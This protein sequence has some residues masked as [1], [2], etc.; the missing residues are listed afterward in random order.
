MGVLE[1]TKGHYGWIL[2]LQ[3]IDHPDA[4]KHQG[5]IYLDTRDIRRGTP[6]CK[7]DE[8]MF[9]LYIDSR[10]LGAEDC[11]LK[12][13]V[14]VQPQPVVVRP[15]ARTGNLLKLNLADLL[16]E[17]DMKTEGAAGKNLDSEANA[18]TASTA[19][20]QS[21]RDNRLA[22][23][24]S[25]PILSILLKPRTTPT[26]V[27]LVDS[28]IDSN[29][30][31][32]KVESS[33]LDADA[34]TTVGSRSSQSTPDSVMTEP[35]SPKADAESF[36]ADEEL[37][38]VD[39]LRAELR[40]ARAR[41]GLLAAKFEPKASEE[42]ASEMPP[43][44]APPPGLSAPES[45]KVAPPPGLAAPPAARSQLSMEELFA[46]RPTS[47]QPFRPPPGFDAPPGLAA[48][49]SEA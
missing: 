26:K 28:I 31:G 30:A 38:L 6:L 16:G 35:D 32:K 13:A 3:E 45:S 33:C 23:F 49:E 42:A 25:D 7:G 18:D 29:T 41:A 24:E 37:S 21:H 11:H 40:E 15:K 2:P 20:T 14:L 46:T 9:Y 5:G 17:E 39:A 43:G 10:G 36:E 48:P 19:S 34:A 12:S 4:G 8:V 22:D 44:F 27:S 47:S 1:E